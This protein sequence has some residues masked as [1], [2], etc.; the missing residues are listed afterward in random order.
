MWPGGWP[1]AQPLLA[2]VKGQIPRAL[3]QEIGTKSKRGE[4]LATIVGLAILRKKCAEHQAIWRLIEKKAVRWLTGQGIDYEPLI[5][6]VI[7]ALTE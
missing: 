5:A 6:R 1:A 7:D 3:E 2:L 4:I